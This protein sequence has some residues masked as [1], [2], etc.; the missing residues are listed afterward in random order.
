[1]QITE[2]LRSEIAL[3]LQDLGRE[4]V[5]RIA[6]K[7][8]CSIDTVYRLWRRIQLREEGRVLVTHPVV[9][10]LAEL[11]VARKRENKTTTKR[12]DKIMKQ[13]SAA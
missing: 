13:L 1:M 4:E 9:L 11:A 6:D 7:C 8:Q 12:I 2:K 5:D 10:E 3:V